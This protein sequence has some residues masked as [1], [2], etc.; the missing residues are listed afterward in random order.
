[1]P[2]TNNGLGGAIGGT[3]TP[4]SGLSLEFIIG[5]SVGGVAIG[6]LLTLGLKR[7]LT[8]KK[9]NEVEVNTG[10]KSRASVRVPKTTSGSFRMPGAHIFSLENV[11]VEGEGEFVSDATPEPPVI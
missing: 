4:E 10:R 1:M 7:I 5:L 2:T 11:N 6:A 9:K 8:T 3:K